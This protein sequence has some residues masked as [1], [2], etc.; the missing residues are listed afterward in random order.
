[1]VAA[2]R[3]E[4]LFREHVDF[5]RWVSSLVGASS[6]AAGLQVTRNDDLP[7]VYD[8][9]L[10]WVDRPEAP[11]PELEGVWDRAFSGSPVSHRH[12][13][14]ED[15][16]A[17]HRRQEEFAAAG[18]V[19]GA[20]CAMLQ[21][22]E[23]YSVTNAEVLVRPVAADHPDFAGVRR[24]VLEAED[25]PVAV[26][27]Q[28][29]REDA[30]E[31][32]RTGCTC[33]VG[34]LRGEPA[35]TIGLHTRGAHGYID[36]VG[37]VPAHRNKGVGVTMLAAMGEASKIARHRFLGLTVEHGNPARRLYERLHYQ[38]L[39]E[40]RTFLRPAPTTRRSNMTK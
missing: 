4:A 2:M 3:T 24:A 39:G 19:P 13:V 27:A 20:A 38:V 12:F 28:L 16:V 8:C 26:V 10:V 35:G 22:G 18:Y 1:M 32:T 11:L 31:A 15:A 14:F 25:Y 29:L 36:F 5:E 40:I 17:A 21:V 23:A 37:T 6:R 34:Y 33:Y 9:N 30:L 7:L